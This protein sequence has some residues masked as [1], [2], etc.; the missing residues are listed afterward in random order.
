[1]ATSSML[2]LLL[3][4]R[5]SF[6]AGMDIFR[7][8]PPGSLAEIEGRMTEKVFG[9]NDAILRAG[10]PA[11]KVWFVKRGHVKAAVHRAN[12]LCQTLCMVG[13]GRMFGAC[14]VLGG[15]RYPCHAVAETDTEVLSLPMGEFMALQAK[16][17]VIGAAVVR[18]VSNL[19]RQSKDER[20]FSR[21]G[22]AKRILHALVE[23]AGKFGA[24]I[25]LTRLEVAE[26]V[27]TTVET[28]I[29]TFRRLEMEGVVSPSRRRGRI[30]VKNMKELFL[31][32]EAA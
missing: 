25:P 26:M 3:A 13:T 14:C 17:P 18:H 5:K 8:V 12:G 32:L 28:S 11:E 15:G 24:E 27:G 31:R 1:M 29:R 16:Y 4:A 20:A 9:R 22:V 6:L 21:E 23:L 30:I 2:G 10:E 7:K 19:L